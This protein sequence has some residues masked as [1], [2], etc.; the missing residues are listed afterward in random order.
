MIQATILNKDY[1]IRDKWEDNTIK[2]MAKAQ[3]YIDNMPKWLENYI[4]SDSDDQQPIS[5][6]KLLA[7]QIDWIELFSDI[8]REYLESE[9]S[10]NAANEISLVELFSLVSKFLGE[11]KEEEL[12]KSEI[13]RLGKKEYKLIKSVKTAGGI[14]KMLGGATYKHFAESQALSSLFQ[15]KNYRKWEYLSRITAILFREDEDEVYDE[16]LIE[17]RSKAFEALPVSEAYK[18]YFFLLG[19][20]NKLQKS[21][22]TS[23]TEKAVSLQVQRPKLLSRILTGVIKRI[24]SLLKVFLIGKTKL[25]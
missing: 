5:E 10:V 18:G 16:E 11:P 1:Q 20:F 3:A 24:K 13:I 12:G 23:L 15:K 25:L 19:H 9:I 8:P 14:D 7:F 22:I 6:S 4:Y 21:T 2:Q 17:M